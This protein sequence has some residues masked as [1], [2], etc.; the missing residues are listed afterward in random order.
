MACVA[1]YESRMRE[2]ETLPEPIRIQSRVAELF[3][4]LRFPDHAL[5]CIYFVVF[6]RQY[7]WW[8]TD[9]NW[10][11]WIGSTF[12]ALFVS[13]AYIASQE[14]AEEDKTGLPFWLII[15]IP[16]LII[17][18]MR[19]A[20][21]DVSFDVLNYHLFHGERTLRG[22]LYLPGEFF[23]T[24]SPFSPAP[25]MVTGI[26]RK[27]FGYRLG[28]IANFLAVI[29]VARIADK[30]L[31]PF[32]PNALLRT[33]G[34]LL[35]ILAEHLLGEINNYMPDI[36]AVPLLLEATYLV[37][38]HDQYKNA[39]VNFVR[40][41][42]LLGI[43]VAFK[44][45]N[46]AF[47][48]P[49][50]LFCTYQALAGFH[51]D[52]K[53]Q[54]AKAIIKFK[55]LALTTLLCAIAFFAA[56]F[57][58]SLYLYRET[59]SPIFPVYNGIFKSVYWPA[60]NVLDPR[61]GPFGW[62]EK[63]LWPILISFKANRLSELPI[64]SGRISSGFVVA[65]IGL[66]FARRDRRF[67]DLCLLVLAGSL[68]W[69]ASTGYIRYA[70]YLEVMA[71][72]VLLALAS[73]LFQ[74]IAPRS[75]PIAIATVTL[76]CLV[77]LVHASLGLAYLSKWELSQR[78][79]FFSQPSVHR[80]EARYLLRDH[81]LTD[82]LPGEARTSLAPVDVWIISSIKTSGLA[83]LLKPGAPMIGVN[84]YEFFDN[85]TSRA[86]FDQALES[87]AGKRMFSLALA[88]DL[89]ASKVNLHRRG[90]VTVQINPIQIPFYSYQTVIA[91]YL[92]ETARNRR[93]SVE[94]ETNSESHLASGNY[95]AQITSAQQPPVMKS[96][97]KEVLRF[98]VRNLGTNLWPSNSPQGWIGAVTIGDRWLTADG[99]N[100]VTEMDSRA[101]VSH[102]VKPG[103][104]IEMVLAVTAPQAPGTYVL[105]IDMV[106]EGVTWFYQQGSRTLRWQ[107]KV[108]NY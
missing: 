80:G 105:E 89:E 74:K 45:T 79:T 51:R 4:R 14:A 94:G 40:I 66:F 30:L 18:A 93:E 98:K 106:H 41:A 46:A 10:I 100:V 37:L 62:L 101:L 64:Y 50:V 107:V 55:P 17:Y 97:A 99:Q 44:L 71:P 96:G 21:P 108:E 24:P 26:F 63:L 77:L 104:E 19:V 90:L 85:Q 67:R 7:F 23:P 27:I 102:D 36:L 43:S 56:L 69:S 65:I 32:V 33:S 91:A 29:W 35:A 8:A 48:L 86:K 87:A 25:D 38:R 81:S 61:W 15:F 83:V 95:R 82:F 42:L 6:A 22:F 49:I 1:W 60:I 84:T 76:L 72:I 12:V 75:R 70:L 20:L 54:Q 103:E 78:P 13:W 31:R 57:P 16:L 5:L 59:G 88:G 68:L 9:N 3:Q 11:A 92:I 47:G 28:T 73:K 39:R 52:G 53:V 2:E 34:V 58:F